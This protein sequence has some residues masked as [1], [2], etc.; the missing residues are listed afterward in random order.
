MNSILKTA[1][2]TE[3][4]VDNFEALLDQMDFKTELE[5]LGIGRIRFRL[6]R[7]VVEECTFLIVGLWYLALLRSFPQTCD[8]ILAEFVSRK[9][10]AAKEGKDKEA[11]TTALYDYVTRLKQNGDADFTEIATYFLR[12]IKVNANDVKSLTLRI[13]LHI[14]NQYTLIFDRLI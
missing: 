4:V 1:Y 12:L 7:Q 11:Y 8:E 14:R 13:A 3:E 5:M 2:T 10:S 9:T 6:R